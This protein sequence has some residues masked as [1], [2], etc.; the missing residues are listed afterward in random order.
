MELRDWCDAL[1]TE[2]AEKDKEI[3]RLDNE[4]VR[5]HKLVIHLRTKHWEEV[6]AVAMMQGAESLD[7]TE[8]RACVNWVAETGRLLKNWQPTP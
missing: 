5:L 3:D 6:R 8:V 1:E 2:N 7:D 4:I